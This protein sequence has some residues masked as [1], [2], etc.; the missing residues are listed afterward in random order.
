[1]HSPAVILISRLSGFLHSFEL[2]VWL[3]LIGFKLYA[4]LF[5]TKVDLTVIE[6]TS[7]VT[8]SRCLRI[9]FPRSRFTSHYR[10]CSRFPRRWHS[11]SFQCCTRR[12]CQTGKRASLDALSRRP[13]LRTRKP[14]DTMTMTTVPFP[15]HE[16]TKTF[17]VVDIPHLLF[18][19]QLPP[20][21]FSRQL[22][23]YE[24]TDISF[25]RHW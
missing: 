1:V 18:I 5:G 15:V 8:F 3:R 2:P 23:F 19:L 21:A 9:S 22:I 11:P 4:F 13:R 10:L 20:L 6:P 14:N 24:M 25:H 12:T 17:L 7:T 16:I